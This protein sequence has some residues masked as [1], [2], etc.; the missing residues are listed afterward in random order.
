MLNLEVRHLLLVKTVADEGTL[1]KAAG[2]L[3]L[4]PSALSHQLH[5]IEERLATPLFHRIGKRMLL[6]P[7]GDR[8][9]E[10]ARRVVD[11]L[12]RAEDDVRL[13]ASGVRGVLRFATECFTCY[14]WLPSLLRRFERRHPRI[15]V[16]IDATA[17]DRAI[18]AVLEGSID[19]AVASSDVDDRRLDI[20]PLFDDELVAVMHNEHRLADRSY[21]TAKDFETEMLLTYATLEES[22]L[23]RRVL[24]PAGVEPARSMRVALTEAMIE[25]ARGGVGIAVASRWSVWPQLEAGA[26]A[27]VPITRRGLQRRWKAVTLRTPEAPKFRDDFIAMLAEASPASRDVPL[28][29]A[30]RRLAAASHSRRR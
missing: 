19:L 28:H 8:V 20:R 7:A 15:D 16:R 3:N 10:S 12:T 25:L 24:R 29:V 27:G 11:D 23:Y 21:L 17:T 14:H 30:P 9:L 26:V 2:M 1:T 6:S 22:T 4:T 13:L 5:D 18:D